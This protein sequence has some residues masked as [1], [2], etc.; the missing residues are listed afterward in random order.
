MRIY[1]NN[2]ITSATLTPSSAA[3]SQDINSLKIPNLAQTFNFG[4]SDVSLI[5]DLGLV[6]NIKSFIIDIG[7][8][9]GSGTYLLE[10]NSTDSWTSPTYSQ[11]LNIT[12]TALYLDLNQT[13]RYFRLKITDS[14]SIKIGYVMIGG[15]YLQFPSINPEA[16]LNY[17]T[18]SVNSTSVSGQI[19]G[20]EG[21]EYLDTEFSFPQIGDVAGPG[22]G[23]VTVAGRQEIK[24]MWN[25]VQNI[26]PVWV[27]LWSNNLE[28]HPPV[29]SILNKSNMSF[30]KLKYGNFFSTT[31]SIREVK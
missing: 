2:L 9:T 25:S 12:D 17:N 10:G 7:N 11:T 31:I 23:G 27:F 30:K 19:Y 29:F 28:E 4:A 16:I 14:E 5:I 26:N 21:Y 3:P 8:M 18:T 24:A 6:V 22:P 1:H 13:F 15:S 20:D